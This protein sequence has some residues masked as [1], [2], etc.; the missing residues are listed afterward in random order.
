M[1]HAT[2]RQATGLA[3]TV[4]GVLSSGAQL[5]SMGTQWAVPTLA[6]TAVCVLVG[7]ALFVRSQPDRDHAFRLLARLLQPPRSPQLTVRMVNNEAELHQVSLIDDEH[8]RD[9]NIT[10]D[11]LLAWWR[12]YPHGVWTLR[13]RG[14]CLG[15]IGFWPL[16]KGPFEEIVKGKRTEQQISAQSID[17][18]SQKRLWYIGGIVVAKCVRKPQA[19][20]ELIRTAVTEWISCPEIAGQIDMVAIA[21]SKE[22]AEMLDRFGFAVTAKDV[23]T[24]HGHPVYA[25]YGIDIDAIREEIARL[26]PASS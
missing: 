2:T 26:T 3:L 25:R 6:A 13:D 12:A 14:K 20:R 8:Y 17:K 1:P 15:A 5:L 11:T 24:V 23:G 18:Q 7:V 10:H 9:E 4:F 21:Y 16:K 22:G 19:L